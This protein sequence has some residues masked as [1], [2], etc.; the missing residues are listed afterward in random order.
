MPGLTAITRWLGFRFSAA[1]FLLASVGAA[2][3]VRLLAWNPQAPVCRMA[4]ARTKFCCCKRKP[5]D[6]G[7]PIL[8]G[9][10]CPPNCASLPGVTHSPGGAIA[11]SLAASE[12]PPQFV[13]SRR[14]PVPV[15]LPSGALAH[16]LYQR[17]PPSA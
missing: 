4:C 1:L 3:V 15:T 6:P 7:K 9:H 11:P 14:E 12:P 5:V 13:L 17:P 2:P 8:L 16:S 10:R